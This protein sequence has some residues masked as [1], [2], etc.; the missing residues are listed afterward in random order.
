MKDA[1]HYLLGSFALFN[2]FINFFWYLARNNGSSTTLEETIF[3][4]LPLKVFDALFRC[5]Q[6]SIILLFADC[7][8]TIIKYV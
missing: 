8:Q 6:R 7:K 4:H 3:A 5:L 2:L 1:Q